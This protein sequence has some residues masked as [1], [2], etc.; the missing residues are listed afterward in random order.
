VKE[1][2]DRLP[3]TIRNVERSETIS[4]NIDTERGNRRKIKWKDNEITIIV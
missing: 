1:W 4:I 2:K 3:Y